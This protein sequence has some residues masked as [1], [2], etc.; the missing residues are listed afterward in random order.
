MDGFDLILSLLIWWRGSRFFFVR[1]DSLWNSSRVVARTSLPNSTVHIYT[2]RKK[3]EFDLIPVLVLGSLAC[4]RRRE[5]ISLEELF[6]FLKGPGNQCQYSNGARARRW[7]AHTVQFNHWRGVLFPHLYIQLLKF[8]SEN[9]ES[10][11]AQKNGSR[12]IHEM[13]NASLITE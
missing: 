8:K 3:R 11:V 7:R 5:Y 12:S 9:R 6:F 2:E 4:R 13:T 10:W 1:L